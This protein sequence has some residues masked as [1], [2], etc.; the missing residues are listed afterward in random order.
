MY[1]SASIVFF[2]AA[3]FVA[4]RSDAYSNGASKSL[5]AGRAGYCAFSGGAGRAAASGAAPHGLVAAPWAAAAAWAA[6]A[7]AS[8]AA[9]RKAIR[10]ESCALPP[11][12]RRRR[13]SS[14]EAES[15]HVGATCGSF[16]R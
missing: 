4:S 8:S 7:S 15:W 10:A 2:H 5:N 1:E 6:A 14:S 16:D 11:A 13:V 12:W 9:S 3:I